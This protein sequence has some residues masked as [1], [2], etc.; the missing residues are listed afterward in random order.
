MEIFA[1]SAIAFNCLCQVVIMLTAE[2]R[3]PDTGRLANRPKSSLCCSVTTTT[4][5]CERN[6]KKN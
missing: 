5:I 3:L 2:K 1:N 4:G 6:F